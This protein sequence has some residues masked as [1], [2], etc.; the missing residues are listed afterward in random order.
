LTQRRV[1]RFC[2]SRVETTIVMQTAGAD[3]QGVPTG[4]IRGSREGRTESEAI[5]ALI[6]LPEQ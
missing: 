5:S 4:M 3:W 6:R 1:K 2:H